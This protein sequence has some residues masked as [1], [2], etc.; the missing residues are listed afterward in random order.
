MKIQAEVTLSIGILGTARRVVPN[1]SL[2]QFMMVGGNGLCERI[3]HLTV[4]MLVYSF[5]RRFHHQDK[6]TMYIKGLGWAKR[7]FF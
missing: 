7:H 4:G 3:L 1:T 2:E 6:N 5:S